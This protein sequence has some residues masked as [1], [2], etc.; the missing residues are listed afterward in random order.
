MMSDS[1]MIK[2][3]SPSTFT[4]LP[5]HLPNSTKSPAFTSG[6]MRLPFSSTGAG[7]DGDDFAF[8]RLFL[9]GVG[10]ND[11]TWGFLVFG[12]AANDHAVAQWAKFHEIS[13]QNYR[14]CEALKRRA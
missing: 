10:D 9:R 4:S 7:T 1:F 12:E 11:S 6:A 8:L 5:D 14:V 13:L 2:S 3:S